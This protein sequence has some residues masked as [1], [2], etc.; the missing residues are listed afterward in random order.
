MSTWP[1]ASHWQT[2]S[3]N[4]VSSTLCLT[5]S[6]D[7]HW[8][9]SSCKSNYHATTTAPMFIVRKV[10]SY[11]L[12]FIHCIVWP[13]LIYVFWL[14]YP[15][16]IFDLRL[17]ITLPIW[18]LWFMSSDY[19]THMVSLIYVFWLHY[20]FG[21]FDLRLLITLPIWCLWFTSSDYITHLV[22]LIYVF[23]L[24]YSF[25]IFDLCL[26]ITLLIWYL[27]FTSSDYITHMVSLIYVFWLHYPFGIFKLFLQTI[28]YKD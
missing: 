2:L 19:I 18:C 1:V 7:R 5:I 17:L 9:H 6:G 24:H 13:S 28:N 8:L 20:P 26:L 14:Y 21:I 22:S 3:H 4:V 15:F 25:G 12:S 11:P 10:W 16:G 27:W 23:W